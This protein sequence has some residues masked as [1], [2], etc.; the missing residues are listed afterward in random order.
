MCCVPIK[1]LN[2]TFNTNLFCFVLPH[3]TDEVPSQEIPLNDIKIPSNLCLADPRFHTPSSVD[4]IIGADVFWDLLGVRKISLG[5][6]KPVL[7]ESRLGWLV[8][9]PLLI[10]AKYRIRFLTLSRF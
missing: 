6:G 3:I 1:S 9:G 10:M 7:I 5:N 2:E 4:L 8:S